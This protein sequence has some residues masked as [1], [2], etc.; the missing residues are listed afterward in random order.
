[1]KV[2]SAYRPFE[3][4]SPAHKK[5]GPFDW[6]S[7]LSM[8]RTSVRASCRCETYALTDE[9]TSFAGPAHRYDTHEPRLMLWL[10]EVWLRYL[11]SPD[12]DDDTVM[13]SPDALVF[14]DLRPW[15]QAD[16]GV[17]VRGGKFAEKP[18]LNGVQFWAVAAK[19]RL[20]AFYQQVRL[21]AAG[22]T[23]DAIRWGGDTY[24]ILEMLAPLKAG[25]AERAGLSVYGIRHE[26]F[27]RCPS[28]ADATRIANGHRPAP[29]TITDFKYLKKRMMPDYFAATYGSAVLA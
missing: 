29:T 27:F 15:F 7:A 5:L 28:N 9:A 11:E 6:P 8:L 10:L 16:L 22:L 21:L 24:P 1:M 12:F 13:I 17:V 3:P 4:E 14:A 18:L 2:V 20:V 26:G 25:H 19:P 23:D